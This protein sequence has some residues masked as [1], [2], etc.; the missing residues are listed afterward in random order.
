MLQHQFQANTFKD[1]LRRKLQSNEPVSLDELVAGVKLWK[2]IGY[3]SKQSALRQLQGH[4][5]AA[6]K[7]TKAPAVPFTE[8][9]EEEGVSRKTKV[10]GT[11]NPCYLTSKGFKL[12][13]QVAPGE[14]GQAWRLYLVEA[15]Q[16]LK[17]ML[18]EESR[19][20]LAGYHGKANT[21]L[22]QSSFTCKDVAGI[23]GS[24]F[25]SLHGQSIKTTKK[26]IKEQKGLRAQVENVNQYD[27][28]DDLTLKLH[29][30]YNAGLEFFA[31]PG[32]TAEEVKEAAVGK[33]FDTVRL[34]EDLTGSQILVQ[35]RTG[36]MVVPFGIKSGPPVRPGD[37]EKRK[38][39]ERQRKAKMQAAEQQL[40][41]GG[42]SV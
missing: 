28:A 23:R 26:Q 40:T 37:A 35:G 11:A 3:G 7:G 16:Y 8:W 42:Q 5:A 19:K 27:H 20:E 39:K 2:A 14:E 31:E 41:L 38:L 17:R 12:L 4:P 32:L 33:T 24:G 25:C 22:F 1:W 36:R 18:S 10:D 13:L 21:S 29:S 30:V 9:S 34:K 6:Q 15:E